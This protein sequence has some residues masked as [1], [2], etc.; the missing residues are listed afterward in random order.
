MDRLIAAW[1][2]VQPRIA[3]SA[4]EAKLHAGMLGISEICGSFT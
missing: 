3:L 2:L 4:G 1:S